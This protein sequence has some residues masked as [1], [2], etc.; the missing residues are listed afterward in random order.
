MGQKTNPAKNSNQVTEKKIKRTYTKKQ[1]QKI[2]EEL[3]LI[4]N[5]EIGAYLRRKGLY[6]SHI[7]NW[8]KQLENGTIEKKP[9]RK[10]T[11]NPQEEANKRLEN[12]ILKLKEKLRQAGLI[13]AA[14]KKI[15]ELI[16]NPII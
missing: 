13:I 11:S 8:K 5:G 10:S 9:G 14:Q 12:E 1:K 2:L 6:S 16:G 4:P 7:Y 3:A 15:A